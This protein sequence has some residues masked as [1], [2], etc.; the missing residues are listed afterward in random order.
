MMVML[1]LP[2]TL[3]AL[4]A[5]FKTRRGIAAAML[6]AVGIA[7]VVALT[8]ISI[9]P[10]F[11][12]NGSIEYMEWRYRFVLALEVTG[13]LTPVT[14]PLILLVRAVLTRL[15]SGTRR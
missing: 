7:Y 9:D 4:V 14:F 12:D 10:Y 2:V 8:L 11:E 5:W 6:L 1:L 3:I 13:W 15:R